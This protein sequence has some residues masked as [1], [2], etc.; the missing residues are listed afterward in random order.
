MN[1]NNGI[2]RGDFIKKSS[3][4]LCALFAGLNAKAVTKTEVA[5]PVS[6]K[7]LNVNWSAPW[8]PERPPTG[9]SPKARTP[10]FRSRRNMRSRP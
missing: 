6:E 3:L 1:T 5:A 9:L 10:L 2:S 7:T 8:Q 4:G